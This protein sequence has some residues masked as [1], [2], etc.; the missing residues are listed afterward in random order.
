MEYWSE[1]MSSG[2]GEIEEEEVAKATFGEDRL[3][4]QSTGGLLLG[5]RCHMTA[6]PGPWQFS[7]SPHLR[8]AKISLFLATAP[9]FMERINISDL[10]LL[11]PVL[12][13]VI[14]CTAIIVL[15]STASLKN[16]FIN[17][18][19]LSGVQGRLLR[20]SSFLPLQQSLIFLVVRHIAEFL[21]TRRK[22][23]SINSLIYY[24]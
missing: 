21:P 1:T 6:Y 11:L 4:E 24:K 17:I 18:H 19:L 9:H 12:Q 22:P 14:S 3:G 10:T 16:C 13:F 8:S 15:I 7:R 2:R 5:P 20:L 23:H